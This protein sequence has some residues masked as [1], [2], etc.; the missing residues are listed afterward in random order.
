MLDLTINLG[1]FTMLKI[2]L[3]IIRNLPT[4]EADLKSVVNEA[5][6]EPDLVRKIEGSIAALRKLA[7]DLETELAG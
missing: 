2:L 7:D 4:V 5:R 3:A 6:D 1:V